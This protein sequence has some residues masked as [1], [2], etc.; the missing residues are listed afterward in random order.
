MA[1][2]LFDEL[3]YL[4]ESFND[5]L[6]NRN[7]YN[8]QVKSKTLKSSITLTEEEL[9]SCKE[10]GVPEEK[11]RKNFQTYDITSKKKIAR[12]NGEFSSCS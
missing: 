8:W 12:A 10:P 3:P 7:F 2:Q 6:F 9:K 5:P 1:H 4:V 11:K